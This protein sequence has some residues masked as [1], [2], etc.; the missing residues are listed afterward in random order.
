MKKLLSRLG[1][2]FG[3]CALV[4]FVVLQIQICRAGHTGIKLGTSGVYAV[5]ISV[6]SAFL[7]AA[8]FDVSWRFQDKDKGNNVGTNFKSV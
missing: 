2:C 3:V 8:F 1:I 4:C 7:S 5:C 6:G